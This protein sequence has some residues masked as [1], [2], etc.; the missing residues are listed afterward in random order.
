[1]N[2][3]SCEAYQVFDAFDADIFFLIHD[4]HSTQI[5]ITFDTGFGDIDGF[6]CKVNP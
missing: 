3:F 2:E 1:M 5:P 4:K 6:A